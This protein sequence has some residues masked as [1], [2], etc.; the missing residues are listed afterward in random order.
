MAKVLV[1]AR[2][3]YPD[4]LLNTL[5]AQAA[6]R[7][8]RG[9]RAAW[10]CALADDLN[11]ACSIFDWE[12]VESANHFWFSPEAKAQMGEWHPV[13]TPEVLVLQDENELK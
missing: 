11:V 5:H 8:S 3:A 10:F 13:G 2:V 12:S 9:E 6:L 4:E 7:K 1:K